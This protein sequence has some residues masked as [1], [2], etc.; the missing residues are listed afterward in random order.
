MW[1]CL[2]SVSLKD[3]HILLNRNKGKFWFCPL[4]FLIFVWF[5]SVLPTSGVFDRCSLEGGR[6]P[7]LS[8]N[9]LSSSQWQW[10]NSLSRAC[11][12][13][14]WWAP[15]LGSRTMIRSNPL[16]FVKFLCVLLFWVLFIC[17]ACCR[18]DSNHPLRI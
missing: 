3:W 1:F 12:T 16:V 15:S 14:G 17:S 8:Q 4:C 18:A 10:V 7:Q 5:L 6:A 13:P 11:T 2:I 9:L